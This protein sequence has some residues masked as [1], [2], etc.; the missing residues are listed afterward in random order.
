MPSRLMLPVEKKC[1]LLPEQPLDNRLSI[2]LECGVRDLTF[3]LVIAMVGVPSLSVSARAQSVIAVLIAWGTC[4]GGVLC[5]ALLSCA[6][7][8]RGE[9]GAHKV[10]VQLR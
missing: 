5:Y 9:R 10:L 2:G 1:H 7:K 6:C 4:N 8:R 3:S